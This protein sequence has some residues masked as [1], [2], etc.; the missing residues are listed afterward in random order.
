MKLYYHGGSFN[1]GCEAIVRS[2][3]RVLNTD[4][5]LASSNVL[6]DRKYGLDKVVVLAEDRY[7][8]P[9]KKTVKWF[10]AALYYKITHSDCLH[11]RY[12][13]KAFFSQVNEGDVYLSIGG[14]NYCY[15][16]Q[17][18]LGF[19][20]KILKEKGA[21]TVLWGCSVEPE[22][23]ENAEIAKDLGRYDLI[24]SRETISYEALKKVNP[25]TILAP[26][27]AFFLARTDLPLEETFMEN[28]TVG[29]N[30]S[31]LLLKN[32]SKSGITIENFENLIQWILEKTSM[33]VALIPHV[34]EPE[35]DDRD[36]LKLL[37]D[38]FEHSKR[39]VM[40]SDCNAEQL[41][42]FIA[43]CRFFVGARTHATIAAYSSEVPTL[44][45]GY[46]V[47]AKGI[48]KDLFGTEENYVLPVQS[49]VKSDTLRSY[50]EWL[51]QHENDIRG[52]L[53]DMLPKYKEKMETAVS[54][55]RSLNKK[56]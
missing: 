26:D 52:H 42:G 29:I 10:L 39:I 24:V 22:L 48:A 15:T 41:K 9:K 2:T 55:V 46:S 56:C 27:P 36:V 16:G 38:K 53:K 32:E 35:N 54:A 17:E 6:S 51:V 25:N 43:R 12:A 14:D 47:K 3:C 50:F 40:V 45:V 5:I 23:T 4:I 1:H 37:Y 20:N 44:V 33:N 19:Y 21:K 49:I 11:I 8:P 13:H 28:N 34:V 31:P 7:D 18:T 30:L